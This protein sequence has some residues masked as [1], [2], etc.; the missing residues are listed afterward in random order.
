[1]A[2]RTTIIR[3]ERIAAS[4]DVVNGW[5][6]LEVDGEVDIRTQGSIREAVHQLLSEGHRHFAL[7]LCFVPFLDSVGLSAVIGITKEIRG[8]GGSLRIA[9]PSVRIR[10]VF[11]YGGLGDAYEFYGSPEEATYDAPVS[12]GLAQWP[13]PHDA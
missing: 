12:H 3:T 7:D 9:S 4:Y 5:T 11:E 2:M 8:Y 1:M 10:H 13:H 6:V